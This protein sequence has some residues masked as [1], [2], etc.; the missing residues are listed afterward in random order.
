MKMKILTDLLKKMKIW[1][2]LFMKM[3]SKGLNIV[4][5]A[6][7]TVETTDYLSNLQCSPKVYTQR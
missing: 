3:K 6:A 5:K 2:D 1:T 7:D 4:D